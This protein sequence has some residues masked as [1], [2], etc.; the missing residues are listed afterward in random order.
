MLRTKLQSVRGA[1]LPIALPV[2]M[3]L[4]V[5]REVDQGFPGQ[6]YI[7]TPLSQGVVLVK[8]AFF[9]LNQSPRYFYAASRGFCPAQRIRLHSYHS[10]R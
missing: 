1:A 10:R 5:A 6:Q 8:V 2:A 4:T 9:P 3:S 7:S